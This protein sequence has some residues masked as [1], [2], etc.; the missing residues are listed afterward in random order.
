ML[1]VALPVWGKKKESHTTL[2]QFIPNQGQFHSNVRFRTDLPNG[3]LFLENTRFTY[4][5]Y[6]AQLRQSLHD[7]TYEGDLENV[8]M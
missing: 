6:D 8:Q 2:Y 1:M 5:F 7:G 3:N 4:H